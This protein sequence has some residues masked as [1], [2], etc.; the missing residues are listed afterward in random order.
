MRSNWPGGWGETTDDPLTPVGEAERE[1]EVRVEQM[2]KAT[3]EYHA[4]CRRLAI[5]K[6]PFFGL[7]IGEAR[8]VDGRVYIRYSADVTVSC[9]VVA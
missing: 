5:L 3:N 7:L 8:V 4:A 6:D 1:V 2:R 9:K